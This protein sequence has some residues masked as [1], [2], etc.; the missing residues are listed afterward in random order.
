VRS[1]RALPPMLTALLLCTGASGAIQDPTLHPLAVHPTR[2][3]VQPVPGASPAALELLHQR[4]G[5]HVLREIPAIRWEVVEVAAERLADARLQFAASPLVAQ[6]EFD[7]VR[8]LAYTPNDPYYP[9]MWNLPHQNVNTA[10]DTTRGSS[11]VLVAVIDTGC[12]RTHPDLAANVWVNPGEIPNNGIDDDGDGLVDDVRGWDFV[13]NDNDPDD[14]FG[15]GTCCA[16]IIAAVQDNNQGITGIAPLCRF[17]PLKACDNSG[18]LFDSY[19]VPALIYAADRGAKVISMS[20][21]GDQV[22]PAE[23][24]A[25]DYCWNHGCLPV[26]A[27]G[28]DSQ[29]FP[30]YPGAYEHTLGVGSHNGSDQK[31]W[32]SNWGSWV[33]VAAPGEGISATTVGGGY[34]TGFAGTSAA[35]PNAAGIAA[36]LFSGVP[37]ATNAQVRA[38]IEDTA[39]GLNQAPYGVWANYGRTDARAALDRLLG[40]SSGSKPARLLFMSPVGGGLSPQL[41]GQSAPRPELLVYG[42]GLEQPNVVRVLRNGS[43]L[44]LLSQSRNEVH[45]LLG[46]NMAATLGLEVNSQVLQS[47]HWDAAPGW[48]FA[49]S[50]A[51]AK[52]PASTTG[53]FLELYRDDGNR[54]TCTRDS[55]TGQIFVQIVL[56][57][58]R[59][60]NIQSIRAEWTRSYS[61][62]NGGT[63]TVQLYDW[64]TWSYPYGSFVT[65]NSAPITNANELHLSAQ[66]PTNPGRFIDP[67]GTVYVQIT[68]TN[69][70]SNALLSMDSFRLHVE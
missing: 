16:G 24:D 6:A 51:N 38:A 53:G 70:G 31:S 36:L 8:R 39:I 19:V 13:N 62:C 18:Y 48:L 46:S 33:D 54:F 32:F 17:L 30:Y 29:T 4:L 5:A 58:V 45:A 44:Q 56:R 3:L 26:A 37:S 25:I 50:D 47:L 15:H 59:A 65:I 23:R 11:S 41:V 14:I 21:Y 1:A 66:L 2:L 57:K 7:H 64:Q 67:E 35:C 61:N 20:F 12:D 28:N 69:A 34:T 52:D 68:A 43:P 9:G 63:E 27:A 10:W 42:L 60:A 22:T 49:P 40:M 55:N